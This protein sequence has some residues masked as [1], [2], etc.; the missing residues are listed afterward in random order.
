MSMLIFILVLGILIAVHE[1]GHFWVAR[2]CGVHVEE[3]AIG[4]G[5]KLIKWK[6]EETEYSICAIPL[7]GYVKM[8]GDERD[9][10]TGSPREFYSQPLRNR[11]LIVLAGP[12]VNY[13]LA[14]FCFMGVFMMGH[15]DM[16]ASS[17]NVPAQI[18]EV[19]VDTPAATAGLKAQDI[20]L[21]INKAAV[22]NWGEMQEVIS[23][24]KKPLLALAIKRG[25]DNLIIN[26]VPEEKKTRDI[27]G[28]EYTVK[29]IGIGPQQ[30]ESMDHLVI[31]RHGFFGSIGRAGQELWMIT[32]KTYESLWQMIIG[33]RSAKES[34]TGLIGIFFVIKYAAQ[35]GFSFLLHI[36]G[37]ISAS[38]AI[39]NLLPLF[40]LD[41]GHLFLYLIEKLRGKPLPEK[42]DEWVAK[43]GFSVIIA[44][45]LFVFYI[46]FERIGLIDKVVQLFGKIGL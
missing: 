4:F 43:A 23:T 36:V 30:L 33:A 20:I 22:T 9:K 2:R 37:V 14:F 44:L 38:L 18:G 27:F 10:C 13:I 40:P 28:K 7:G 6:G 17:N 21:S 35:V 8:A 32:Y 24:T 1:W 12:V 5:P 46:D 31:E 16:E 39:F 45:A 42:V 15:I 34:M 29:R 3:F 41:G 19:L 11:A 26:V 25:D